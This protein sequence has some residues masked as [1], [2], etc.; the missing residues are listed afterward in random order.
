M[1]AGTEHTGRL[2]YPG[3][4]RPRSQ[5]SAAGPLGSHL[6]RPGCPAVGELPPRVPAPDGALRG[7]EGA[8][9][10]GA[11]HGWACPGSTHP[12]EAQVQGVRGWRSADPGLATSTCGPEG[13]E[14]ALRLRVLGGSGL[15]IGPRRASASDRQIAFSFSS[16]FLPPILLTL[17]L[18]LFLFCTTFNV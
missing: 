16:P 7:R 17:F 4:A 6:L 18:S 8:G 15:Q 5:A 11:G 10:R 9:A 14:P 1:A 12:G 13:E 2:E 3:R